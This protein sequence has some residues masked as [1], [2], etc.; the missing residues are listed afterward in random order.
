VAERA[1][2]SDPELTWAAYSRVMV[3]WL[4]GRHGE[5]LAAMGRY[6]EAVRWLQRGY[7]MDPIEFLWFRQMPLPGLPEMRRHPAFVDLM[8]R[9]VGSPETCPAADLEGRLD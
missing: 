9:T 8:A 3:L 4:A 1:V 6:E 2:E 5:A 7:Q